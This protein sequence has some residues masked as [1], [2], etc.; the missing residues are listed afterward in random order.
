MRMSQCA[1]LSETLVIVGEPALYLA[2][3]S[4]RLYTRH[5][6]FRCQSGAQP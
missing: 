6:L 2:F 3:G 1:R 4:L 5:L